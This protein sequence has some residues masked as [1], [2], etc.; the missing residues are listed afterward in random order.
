MILDGARQ[1]STSR[2]D[3][4]ATS[5]SKANSNG[6]KQSDIKSTSSIKDARLS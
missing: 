5:L 6:N 3:Q 2:F 4:S 1:T